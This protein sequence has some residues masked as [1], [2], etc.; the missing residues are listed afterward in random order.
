MLEHDPLKGPTEIPFAPVDDSD[1]KNYDE[2]EQAVG[3]AL[4]DRNFRTEFFLRL[5]RLPQFQP[6]AALIAQQVRR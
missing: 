5:A 6:Y 2:V 4:F 1:L 3:R